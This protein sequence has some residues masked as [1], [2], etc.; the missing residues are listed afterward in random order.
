MT[1]HPIVWVI[2]GS[3]SSGAAGL[4]ADLR[5]LQALGVHGACVVTAVT[6]QS[7]DG[8]VAAEPVRP[9]MVAAQIKAIKCMGR[10]AAVKIGMLGNGRVVRAVA[11]ALRDVDAPII[12]DPVIA[13]TSGGAL[14]DGDGV[15]ALCRELLP[16]AALITPNA[17]EAALLT[18]AHAY[19]HPYDHPYDHQGIALAASRL[20]EMGARAVLIKGGHLPSSPDREVQDFFYDFAEDGGAL[21]LAS[22][23]QPGAAR[24]TGCTLA[25]AIA[26]FLAGGDPLA[27][28]VVAARTYIN[29]GFRD[30]SLGGVLGAQT[31]PRDLGHGD[32]PVV[33]MADHGSE[34]FPSCG[35]SPLGF[36][37][38]VDRAAWVRRVLGAGAT[39][40]Q[41]RIKDL[42][43]ASLQGEIREAVAAARVAGARLFINDY[44]REAIASEAYGVHLGQED[45]QTADLAAI[46]R[47]GLRLGVSTHSYLEAARAHALRPS[48]V[49]LGPIFPTTCKSMRFGPQG[50]GR[51]AL[52]RSLLP[53][54]LVAIGG[55]KL[56]HAGAAL[57]AGADGVAVISDVTQAA[58]PDARTR[59]W[60]AALAKTG[61]T[62][63]TAWEGRL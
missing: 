60:V 43:G 46:R 32:L 17:P 49:A 33:P 31:W 10:P 24:G 56:E 63:V 20:K 3:D 47:A 16:R 53:Y 25:S 9:E 15:A 52:W 26:A 38:V 58:D 12:L 62:P 18:G 61:N 36:Y 48:Y 41:L 4:Q 51:L 28:A 7:L 29:R 13:S 35:P 37:P 39:T 54:P 21:T 50:F 23:R 45:V 40:V 14:I 5:T 27:D 22:S 11:E 2:A 55:L 44:W 6:A 42:T 19:D 30:R 1:A 59:A 34:P 8:F 57:A